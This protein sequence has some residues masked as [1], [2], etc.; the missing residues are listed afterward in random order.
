MLSESMREQELEEAFLAALPPR[1]R[2][3]FEPSDQ[4]G[5]E[6]EAALAAARARFPAV[7]IDDLDFVRHAA[8][9]LEEPS[10]LVCARLVDL[11]LAC[12]AA[13]GSDPAIRVFESEIFPEIAPA[14]ARLRLGATDTGELWQRLREELFVATPERRA[15]IAEYSARG[16]LRGWLKVT[17]V[18]LGFKLLRGRDDSDDSGLEE[19]AASAEDP[20]L[21]LMKAE[22]RPLFKAAFQSALDSLPARDRLILRQHVLDGLNIDQLGALHGV[23]RATAARWIQSAREALLKGIRRGLMSAAGISDT[24]CDGVMN[25][26]RSQLDTTLRR[27]LGSTDSPVER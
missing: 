13:K 3:H 22:Y 17:A 6:L 18:R 11:V 4:P 9:R 21:A 12:A 25:L 1:A 27:R 20:E 24:E 14:L 2:E 26:V 16:D 15:K 8:E 10:Q 19:H 5:R 7:I 23:H